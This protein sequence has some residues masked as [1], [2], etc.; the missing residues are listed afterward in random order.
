MLNIFPNSKRFKSNFRN[1]QNWKWHR[2]L[3]VLKFALLDWL[4]VAWRHIGVLIELYHRLLHVLLFDLCNRMPYQ[5]FPRV[6]FP[7]RKIEYLK[8]PG[9]TEVNFTTFC[10]WT[11]SRGI[12]FSC[13]FKIN[14]SH[15]S[16]WTS[17]F[18]LLQY[19]TS[20]QQFTSACPAS[21]LSQ[22]EVV[23]YIK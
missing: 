9:F 15:G 22:M 11:S 21:L 17:Q 3:Y 2:H 16:K 23:Y 8:C 12:I 13:M 19:I 14:F 4:D 5:P 7:S 20:I 18:Y 10:Q 6:W 1:T